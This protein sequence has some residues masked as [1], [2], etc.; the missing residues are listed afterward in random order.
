MEISEIMS[1]IGFA[2][3][4]LLGIPQIIK[5]IKT[6]SA[7]DLSLMTFVLILVSCTCLLVRAIAIR[8]T[9]FIC[10][11]AILILSSAFQIFLIC[12]YEGKPE[13]AHDNSS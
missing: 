8:E 2:A 13:Q 10:Y 11:Y 3:G 9:S 5:T 6:K 1:W 7:R 4:A 12:K